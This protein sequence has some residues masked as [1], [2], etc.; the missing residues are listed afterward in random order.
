M[1]ARLR[2]PSPALLPC[3]SSLFRHIHAR[4]RPRP[5]LPPACPPVA[6]PGPG[7]V[8]LPATPPP[9][10]VSPPPPPPPP[11]RP[12]ELEPFETGRH[13]MHPHPTS[14]ASP[15]RRLIWRLYVSFRLR[16][17][18]ARVFSSSPRRPA[19]TAH[20]VSLPQL[21]GPVLRPSVTCR[22]RCNAPGNVPD[23]RCRPIRND[24]KLR[25]SDAHPQSVNKL[26]PHR[27]RS[28]VTRA[29]YMGGRCH[30]A[31]GWRVA[32]HA[33]RRAH[34]NYRV[35][36][37]AAATPIAQRPPFCP[38]RSLRPQPP[39]RA[40]GPGPS[41]GNGCTAHR[42]SVPPTAAAEMSD[43]PHSSFD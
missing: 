17:S 14:A 12:P 42:R 13:V 34:F 31:A 24:S 37:P 11:S 33:Q 39:G 43:H 19:A 3:P 7:D 22:L 25:H 18:R 4:R 6:C 29:P 40:S 20:T 21:P 1:A 23:T 27:H 35:L 28:R 5:R 30:V 2:S 36:L 10:A 41:L 26:L 32:A 38:M 8:R 15:C 9:A 16:L